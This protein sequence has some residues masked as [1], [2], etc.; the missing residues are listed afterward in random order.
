MIVSRMKLR[1]EILIGLAKER[2]RV[3]WRNLEW[4]T[5]HKE[6]RKIEIQ[7]HHTAAPQENPHGK[8]SPSQHLVQEWNLWDLL[9]PIASLVPNKMIIWS[10][11][12]CPLISVS[13]NKCMEMLTM[14]TLECC[15]LTNYH[16]PS[17]GRGKNLTI[18][19][20]INDY[21]V[22]KNCR[23]KPRKMCQFWNSRQIYRLFWDY[24]VQDTF[25]RSSGHF[26]DCTETFQI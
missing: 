7:L 1:F 25:L 15:L 20:S 13:Q 8:V 4:C 10:L 14:P 11:L 22:C 18:P 2:S 3:S 12:F 5:A 24:P 6:N 23:D 19:P 9:E 26:S 21:I 17:H 16:K